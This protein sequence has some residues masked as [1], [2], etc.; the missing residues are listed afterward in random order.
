MIAIDGMTEEA[1]KSEPL[2]SITPNGRMPAFHDPNT[3]AKLW[4][5]SVDT[6]QCS[7]TKKR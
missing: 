1:K 3:G 4:E 2:I 7:I 6:C 5:V